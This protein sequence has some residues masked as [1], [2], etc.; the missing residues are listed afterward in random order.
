MGFNKALKQ[1]AKDIEAQQQEASRARHK[2]SQ[3]AQQTQRGVDTLTKLGKDVAAECLSR[4]RPFVAVC[5]LT[6]RKPLIG[7]PRMEIA[8]ESHMWLVGLFLVDKNGSIYCLDR[9]GKPL[10]DLMCNSAWGRGRGGGNTEDS[11]RAS[12]AK[13]RRKALERFKVTEIAARGHQ[14]TVI[15]GYGSGEHVVNFTTGTLMVKNPAHVPSD[16][17]NGD[18]DGNP[19]NLDLEKYLAKG[20]LI[21]SL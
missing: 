1:A 19:M 5:N 3:Q 10:E 7:R 12:F 21:K 16:Y 8:L 14:L 6:W 2:A 15:E 4:D 11:R 17:W 20:V 18:P 9:A 13:A